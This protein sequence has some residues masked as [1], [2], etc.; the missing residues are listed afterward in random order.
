M[1]T[2]EQA[3][4][5]AEETR[6]RM[7][8]VEAALL[9][10]LLRA[11]RRTPR[12]GDLQAEA[13][14]L[15][16]DL[17]QAYLWGRTAAAT[18]GAERVGAEVRALAPGANVAAFVAAPGV[19][20][21]ARRAHRAG[22]GYVR[23]WLPKALDLSE[24]GADAPGPAAHTALRPALETGAASEAAEAFNAERQ[25]VIRQAVARNP[26]LAQAL[27]QVWDAE[28]DKRTCER[29]LE[30]DAT[31]APLGE[32]FPDGDPPLHPRCRCTI[33]IRPRRY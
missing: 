30:L 32:R 11:T 9:L 8:A 33:S 16:T 1:A 5:E 7:L 29:C 26:E 3:D 15:Y 27:E 24:Q 2:R 21:E 18:A 31:S 12:A 14:R 28:L 4:R 22:A 6:R 10:L 20:E 25:R 19:L 23:R 13:D 17:A